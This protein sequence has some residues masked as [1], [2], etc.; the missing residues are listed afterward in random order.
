MSDTVRF[1]VDFRYHGVAM[2]W[3]VAASLATRTLKEVKQQARES[4][5]RRTNSSAWSFAVYEAN[6]DSVEL[7]NGG[8]RRCWTKGKEIFATQP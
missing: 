6:C 2:D 8:V 7:G 3:W 5:A 4:I 1:Y